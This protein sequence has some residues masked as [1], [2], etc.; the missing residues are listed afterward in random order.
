MPTLRHSSEAADP[1]ELRDAI[2]R[3]VQTPIAALRATLTSLETEVEESSAGR[4]LLG[5]ALDVLVDLDRTL[6][7][8]G[9][10]VLRSPL[11][12]LTCSLSEL[13]H[14]AHSSLPESRRG[15]VWVALAKLSH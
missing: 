5:R 9:D 7:A 8:L 3:D 13:V 12:P 10:Y 15:R 6:D 11:R 1:L 14:S 4:A 2:G